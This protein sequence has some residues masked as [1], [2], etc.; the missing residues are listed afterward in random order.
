MG[1]AP[2]SVRNRE[3]STVREVPISRASEV[4]VLVAKVIVQFALLS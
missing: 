4:E 1:E 3:A 2:T